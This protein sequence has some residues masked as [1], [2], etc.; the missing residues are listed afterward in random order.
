M[1]KAL[2]RLLSCAVFVSVVSGLALT[3]HGLLAAEDARL[4]APPQEKVEEAL[5][6]IRDAYEADYRAA[7]ESGEP[8]QLIAQLNGLA[9]GEADPVRKYALFVEAE[10][11]ASSH[12]NFKK[13]VELLDARA[14]LFR[15]DGLALRS[16]L[17]KRL[18]GPKVSADLELCD[19][20]MDTAQKAMRSERFG[21]ASEAA[22]L[23]VN[24]A[25]AVDREQKAAMR[26]QRKKDGGN[27]VAPPPI[28]VELVKKSAALQAQ[29]M[30]TEKLFEQYGDAVQKAKSSPDSPSANVVIGSYLCFVRQDWKAGLP[31]LAKSD[32]KEFSTLAASEM[33][34]AAA[35]N[36][37]DA[38]KVFALAGRWWAAAESKGV[39]ADHESAIKDHAAVLYAGIGDRLTDTLQKRVA[40]SRLRGL[41]PRAP[42]DRQPAKQTPVA[43]ARNPGPETPIADFTYEFHQN[44]AFITLYRGKETK[45][46][47]PATILGKPV[48]GLGGGGAFKDRSDLVSVSIPDTVRFI[49]AMT[50]Y[51]CQKLESIALPPKLEAIG[52]NAFQGCSS[53]TEVRIPASVTKIEHH[54]FIRCHRLPEIIVDKDNPNYT[55]VDG[56]LYDKAVTE[57]LTCPAGKKG[58]LR[59]PSTVKK[60]GGWVFMGCGQLDRILIPATTKEIA[61][62]AFVE[63]NAPHEIVESV[64]TTQT[65]VRQEGT[66]QDQ[67]GEK[68]KY[69][70]E[71]GG[72]VITGYSG[73]DPE[74]TIPPMIQGRPV[75]AIGK[76]A[77]KENVTVTRVVLP[78]GLIRI[79]GG[80]FRNCRQLSEVVIPEGVRDI[81]NEA[82]TGTALPTLTLPATL[83]K[84]GGAPYATPHLASINVTPGNSF[85][86]SIDGI[87]YDKKE[88]ALIRCP[89]NR[90]EPVVLP[91][92]VRVI[93]SGAFMGCQHLEE[94]AL[95]AGLEE[96][97]GMAFYG[98]GN[99]KSIA[100]PPKVRKINAQTFVLCGRLADVSFS[101]GLES[102]DDG[103]FW[104][105]GNLSR[106]KLPKSLT[107][108][109]EGAFKECPAKLERPGVQ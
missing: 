65:A 86:K 83:E 101:E 53:L 32:L 72:V 37:M 50:F 87:L 36:Q 48:C 42:V 49:A 26:K 54:V 20:A 19:Q 108:L 89:E 25:K 102:I 44:E 40:A 5:A 81:E 95:P 18:A 29:V 10:N 1:T 4:P 78:R 79:G 103:V 64:A 106:V 13:A 93:G 74:V 105:C 109:H 68:L 90:Q 59:I 2:Y 7:K 73:T 17:L 82:L 63:C 22:A 67:G 70:M 80:A 38:Q 28:G 60:I 52:Y 107:N 99:L 35:P 12:D 41:S 51:D 55:T 8:E 57:L 69:A 9:S 96:I 3:R 97:G 104:G 14:E 21:L 45:V 34:L 100:I 11:V 66:N 62:Q 33:E 47:I 92:T 39:S 46:V 15:I 61:D 85:F 30:A 24:I 75:I 71:A 84:L 88:T 98:C 6:L 31:A 56:V 76:G 94:I 16:D 23:A 77:F 58:V 91:K 43:A 27:F